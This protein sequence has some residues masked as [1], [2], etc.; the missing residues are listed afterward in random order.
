M[1]IEHAIRMIMYFELNKY[2]SFKKVLVTN[3]GSI[4][5]LSGSVKS[6]SWYIIT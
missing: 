1:Y 2:L 5:K 4:V 6:L 3:K